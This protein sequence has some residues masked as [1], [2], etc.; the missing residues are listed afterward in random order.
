MTGGG[1]SPPRFILT[2][3]RIT[4]KMDKV[5]VFLLIKKVLERS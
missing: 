4:G 2:D 1:F 3:G 5:N